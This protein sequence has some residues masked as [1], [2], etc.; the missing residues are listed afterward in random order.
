[1]ADIDCNSEMTNFHRDNV[2]LSNKQQGEMRTRRN[3][4]RTRL[5]NGLNEAK[6]W[7]KEAIALQK[8]LI[9]KVGKKP[10]MEFPVQ[11][12]YTDEQYAAVSDLVG[13][14]VAEAMTIADKAERT[15]AEGSIRDE[16]LGE[17]AAIQNLLVDAET[18]TR[19]EPA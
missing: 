19:K 16:V 13:A 18:Y 7:I 14:K 2:T 12:D 17:L 6:K 5:E 10:V 11:V 1:M 9:S 8:E 15:A 4:G 3:A